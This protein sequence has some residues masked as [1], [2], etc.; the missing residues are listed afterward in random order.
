MSNRINPA[1][2]AALRAH[3]EKVDAWKRAES[4]EKK[5]LIREAKAAGRRAT[6]DEMLA[7]RWANPAPLPL[8]DFRGLVAMI[9]VYRTTNGLILSHE[10]MCTSIRR[11]LKSL[12]PVAPEF[13]MHLL[14]SDGGGVGWLEFLDTSLRYAHIVI[15]ANTNEARVGSPKSRTGAAAKR[16]REKG[17]APLLLAAA[18]ESL[19]ERG[20]WGKSDE[21]I[22]YL[23]A[24]SRSTFYLLLK[25]NQDIKKAISLYRKASRG[26]GPVRHGDL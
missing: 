20:D 17:T 5:R 12:L 21:E 3:F 11:K 16:R 8:E 9:G 6:E 15:F 24:I 13:V 26:R 23:A 7:W 10:E 25:E 19:M 4:E 2:C 18:I 22:C 1:E 14:A